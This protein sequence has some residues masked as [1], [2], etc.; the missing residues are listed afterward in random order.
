MSK[1]NF[2]RDEFEYLVDKCM[3]NE[4]YSLILEMLIKNYSRT[5]IAM[6]LNMSVDTLDKK[7]HFIKKK[8]KRVL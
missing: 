1:L 5:R 6:K 8:I 3:F 4:E 7:I 2:T